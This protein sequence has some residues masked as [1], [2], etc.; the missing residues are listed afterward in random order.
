[1]AAPDCSTS[2]SIQNRSPFVVTVRTDA[3]LNR[4][5]AY[6]RRAEAEVYLKALKAR[7]TKAR[8]EQLETA[9]QLRIRRKGVP[10]QYVTFDT[11]EDAQQAKLQIEADLSV[12]V[13]RDYAIA[14][15][16]TLRELMERYLTEVV[17]SHKGADIEVTRIRRLLRDEAFVD[18]KLAALVTEDLQ[19]YIQDRLTEVAPATVDRE[20][21]LISQTLS[22]AND[23]WKIA[24]VESP[25]TGLRRPK[26]FNERDRRL[27][28]EEERAILAAAREDANPYIEPAIILAL[29]TAMRRGELLGLKLSDVHFA[30]RYLFLPDTK[31]G[32]SRKV[33]LSTR[34]E[35][36]ICA[37]LEQRTL[38]GVPEED[39]RLLPLTANAFKKAFFERVLPHCG[40]KDLH[41]HDMR[42]EA[43]SRFAESGLFSLLELQAISGHRDVRMLQRYAHLLAGNLAAKIDAIAGSTTTSYVHRGRR[44]RVV[45]EGSAPIVAA[46]PESL[47]ERGQLRA[48]EEAPASACRQNPAKVIDFELARRQQRVR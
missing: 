21:D 31:N 13:V 41:F 37:L 43:I 2:S 34:A 47:L 32:R 46:T 4:R 35:T 8:I 23:V 1:M 18:K 27:L 26:Y 7:G 30:G 22:Y 48:I 42:H 19:D 44:R 12:S 9:F 24:P 45:T 10:N 28:P 29:E 40:V 33:P 17:P 6:S 3:S 25:F 38:H 39:D 15:R 14:T 36:V 5:F 16:T 20:L 11:P